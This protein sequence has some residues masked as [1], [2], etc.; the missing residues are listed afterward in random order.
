MLFIVKFVF[1][2]FLKNVCYR[3]FFGCFI[4]NLENNCFDII[5]FVCEKKIDVKDWVLMYI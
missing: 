3:K 2:L 1:L 4:V 5:I